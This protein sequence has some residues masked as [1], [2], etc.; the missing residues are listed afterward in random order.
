M[1]SDNIDTVWQ[2]RTVP[3]L[4]L[5]TEVRGGHTSEGAGYLGFVVDTILLAVRTE[6]F[7]NHFRQEINERVSKAEVRKPKTSLACEK[8]VAACVFK[9]L[10]LCLNDLDFQRGV[11]TRSSDGQVSPVFGAM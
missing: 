10:A 7:S 5:S 2:E 3:M 9:K 8:S 4:G 1:S 11:L 6:T